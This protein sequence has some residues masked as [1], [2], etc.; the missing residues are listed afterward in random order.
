MFAS[1]HRLPI[2]VTAILLLIASSAPAGSAPEKIPDVVVHVNSVLAA[3]TNEGV[4]PRLG[5]MGPRLKAMFN[6]S[7]YRLVSHEDNEAPCGTVVSF[8][9]PGGRFLHIRP[10]ALEA[11]MISMEMILF[12]GPRPMLTT[13]LKL[14]NNG[15]LILGGPHYQQGIIILTIGA[16][17]VPVA[18]E[19]RPHLPVHTGP[20]LPRSEASNSP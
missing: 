17:A 8:E 9:L 3:P 20:M 1:R 11:G 7:T 2:L 10:I 15:Q 14:M 18:A 4:D 16:S 5:A 12:Q 6:Y 19:E 13:D